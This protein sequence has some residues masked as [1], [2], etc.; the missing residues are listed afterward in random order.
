MLIVC[1][2][3]LSNLDQSGPSSDV[4]LFNSFF[5]NKIGARHLRCVNWHQCRGA[6]LTVSRAV[7]NNTNSW[8][9]YASVRK[10]TKSTDIFSKKFIVVPINEE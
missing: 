7:D 3:M 10:W 9:P 6:Q 4:H 8:L 5:Y 1:R 2:N